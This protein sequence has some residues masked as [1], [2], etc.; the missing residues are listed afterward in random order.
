MFRMTTAKDILAD[1]TWKS[2]GRLALRVIAEEVS[3][4]FTNG[5]EEAVRGSVM[6]TDGM[7]WLAIP[8]R[9]PDGL[10]TVQISIKET[11]GNDRMVSVSAIVPRTVKRPMPMELAKEFLFLGTAGD[12]NPAKVFR[13]ISECVLGVLETAFPGETDFLSRIRQRMSLEA[14]NADRAGYDEAEEETTPP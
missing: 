3:A 13:D 14:G 8:A 6:G 1:P 12:W 10:R 5:E 7:M 4:R 11:P 9:T 2:A